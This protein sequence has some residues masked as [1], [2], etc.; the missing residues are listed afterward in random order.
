MEIREP[1]KIMSLIIF[2]DYFGG[3]NLLD[4]IQHFE[5][6]CFILST[7]AAVIGRSNI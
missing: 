2:P 3:G 7:A 1:P 4:F 5:D 6:I